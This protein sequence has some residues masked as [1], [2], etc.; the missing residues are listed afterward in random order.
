MRF[1]PSRPVVTVSFLGL[2]V[3][4]LIAIIW[5]L[6]GFQSAELWIY[7]DLVRWRAPQASTDPRIA[8]VMLDDGDIG[9]YDYPLRDAKLAQ[10][11]ETI[12]RDHPR[13]IGLDLY[14]DLPEPRDGSE[15]AQLN[16]V[17]AQNAN[18]IC[19]FLY[20]DRNHPDEEPFQVRPPSILLKVRDRIAFNNFAADDRTVRRGFTYLPDEYTSLAWQ[21][22]LLYLAP[23]GVAPRS[24]GSSIRLGKSV[25]PR[26][27]GNEGGYV[28]APSKGYQFLFDFKGPSNFA[29]YTVR[30]VLT[31][32]TAGAFRDK[33][34]LIG[35]SSETAADFYITPMTPLLPAER[36][37]QTPG[38]LIHA[39]SVNQYLR[40]ALDGDAPTTGLS[41]AWELVLLLG[42]CALATGLG[43]RC[44]SFWSFSGALTACLIAMF[45]LTTFLFMH[46]LWL[47]SAGP[48]VGIL[49]AAI[50]AKAY[51]AQVEARD[52]A[53]LMRLFSRHVSGDVAKSI[54]EHRDEFVEGN[55]PRAQKLTATVFF[56]DLKNYSTIAEALNPDDLMRWINECLGAL[57]RH[58]DR[59][60][61]IIDKYIG[62]SIMAVFGAPVPR[63]TEQEIRQD[64]VHAVR[65]AW[66][67]K[68]EIKRLNDA[69][70]TRGLA[71]VGLR[72]GIYTGE[73]M[74][75]AVGH[76][77]R[78]EY[79]VIGD[80]VNTASRLESLDK[81]NA[82]EQDAE[83]RILIGEPTFNLV[84][85]RFEVE[86]MGS[87]QL[88]GQKRLTPFYRI[89]GIKDVPEAKL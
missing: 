79:T 71:R 46:H 17:L 1:V 35:G 77:D 78:L 34:V 83:C 74:Y 14:R 26:F 10:L 82:A 21:L 48:G 40:A 25:F 45:G 6:G 19:I 7:D 57:A 47:A 38:V 70:E 37:G 30:Q 29:T 59:N 89:V 84:K 11:L 60:G 23:D 69:W 80:S 52:R 55:R 27:S 15:L 2:G 4:V 73:L 63:A 56:T 12:E 53:A 22:A 67:M 64:A 85:D 42:W 81:E 36:N 24:E 51:T 43:Y 39:Q 50:G 65:C 54:W 76:D 31:A 32:Q 61:G 75:G 72:I 86:L 16:S 20:D 66:D 9:K 33:I 58:V 88:K 28:Q 18:I 87:T 62:D 44:H 8:L 49:L 5:L 3:F 41:T 13:V 68:A